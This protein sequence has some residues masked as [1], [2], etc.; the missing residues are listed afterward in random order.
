MTARFEVTIYTDGACSGNPGPGGW[1]AVLICG[2][3]RKEISGGAVHTT[4][5][6][7]EMTAA[8]QALRQLKQRSE[9]TLHSDSRYLVQG[10][11]EWLPNWLRRGWRRP[12]GGEVAN[13][14]LWEEL[15]RL[16]GK[17]QIRW[18]WLPAH[19]DDPVRSHPENARCDELARGVIEQLRANSPEAGA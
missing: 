9:V 14:T 13:R 8:V 17:H 18:Q 16:S 4:N 1:A 5:N 10:M 7:M 11:K 6:I 2:P 12:G 3:H 15:H 19:H